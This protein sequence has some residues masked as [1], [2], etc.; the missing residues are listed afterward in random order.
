MVYAADAT[1]PAIWDGVSKKRTYTLARLREIGPVHKGRVDFFSPDA[2]VGGPGSGAGGG[3]VALVLPSGDETGFG[4]TEVGM[5]EMIATPSLG[6]TRAFTIAA[7]AEE[8]TATEVYPVELR[9]YRVGRNTPLS[10]KTDSTANWLDDLD[11]DPGKPGE[12][13][14]MYA[15]P[16]GATALSHTFA[17]VVVYPGD[18]VFAVVSYSDN[19][20][21]DT[22]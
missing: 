7:A 5:G 13:L 22:Y 4:T 21:T 6:T 16:N 9:L 10:A 3:A 14:G 17:G 12:L 2:A 20:W 19:V 1:R 8:G 18:A 11:N 15:N